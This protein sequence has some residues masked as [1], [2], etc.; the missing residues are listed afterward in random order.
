M[1]RRRTREKRSEEREQIIGDVLWSL[2]SNGGGPFNEGALM[3]LSSSG[4][5]ICTHIPLAK[6][7]MVK[8]YGRGL[9]EDHKYCRV[10]WT[11]EMGT[12][13]FQSGLLQE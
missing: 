7:T 11:R 4:M 12:S 9:W 2:N 1:G 5:R 6:G 10:R 13:I 3:D 8:L